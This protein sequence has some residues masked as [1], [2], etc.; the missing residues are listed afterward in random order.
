MREPADGGRAGR[1]AGLALA[2]DS[3]PEYHDDAVHALRSLPV[4]FADVRADRPILALA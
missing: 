1:L 2:P 4:T 3:P